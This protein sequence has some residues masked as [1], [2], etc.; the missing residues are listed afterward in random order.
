MLARIATASILLLLL[1]AGSLRAQPGTKPDATP[2]PAVEQAGLETFYVPDK[3]TGKLIP[4]FRALTFDEFEKLYKLQNQLAAPDPGQ[5]YS[6]QSM[7]VRGSVRGDNATLTATLRIKTVKPGWSKVDLR[8][9]SVL[10]TR[11]A[12]YRGPGKAI[13]DYSPEDKHYYCLVDG[14][15]DAVHTIEMQFVVP[16]TELGGERSLQL[17]TPSAVTSTLQLTVPAQGVD[18]SS[19]KGGVFRSAR[20]QGGQ[21]S[22]EFLGL[23]GEFQMRW[24]PGQKKGGGQQRT[25]LE[26]SALLRVSFDGRFHTRSDATLKVNSLSGDFNSFLVRLPAGMRLVPDDETFAQQRYTVVELSEQEKLARKLPPRLR[27]Q[28]L[29][30]VTLVRK[31]SERVEVNLRTVRRRDTEQQPGAAAE[32][33]DAAG[34]EVIGASNQWGYIELAV[35]GDW[36]VQWQA[37]HVTQTGD[38][39]AAMR[40]NN[41]VARFE[42]QQQPCQLMVTVSPRPER[43]R[44]EPAYQLK[45]DAVEAELEARIR[46]QVRGASQLKIN[47]PG[48]TVD[49][50]QPEDLFEQSLTGLESVE[51]LVLTLTPGAA[52]ASTAFD[53][54]IK[55]RHATGIGNEET[56]TRLALP[57]PQT[58]TTAPATLTVLPASEIELE[59]DASNSAGLQIRSIPR[60]AVEGNPGALYYQLRTG[61]A[62]IFSSIAQKR[63]RRV[64][65]GSDTQVK[66]NKDSASVAQTLKFN[67]EFEPVESLLV[68]L[69]EEALGGDIE[70][71]GSA[72]PSPS[73]Q[74]VPD[75][76]EV[77]PPD[78][79]PAGTVLPERPASTDLEANIEPPPSG[80][81]QLFNIL[82]GRS[83]LGEFQ[84]S[85]R[86]DSAL[87]EEGEG[88]AEKNFVLPLAA[89]V[90][91]DIENNTLQLTSAAWEVTPADGVWKSESGKS[92]PARTASL[93]ATGLH[94]QAILKLLRL[95]TVKQTAPRVEKAWLQTTYAAEQRRDRAVFVLDTDD[96]QVEVELPP[97]VEASAAMVT[98]GGARQATAVAG[99]RLQVTLPPVAG[100]HVI[101]IWYMLQEETPSN[102]WRSIMRPQIAGARPPQ[103][104]Y[105]QVV[106]PAQQ[107]VLNTPAGMNAEQVAGWDPFL[108]R[109]EVMTQRELEAWTGSSEQALPPA[110]S[111]TYLYSSFTSPARISLFTVHSLPMMLAASLLVMLCGGL[112]IYWEKARQPVVWMAF[113]SVLLAFAV[114][115]P[116]LAL[117]LAQATA[118]GIVLTGFMALL[119]ML[120][121]RPGVQRAVSPVPLN[122]P[123][124]F[125]PEGSSMPSTMPREASSL[126]ATASIQD[127]VHEDAGESTVYTD[128]PSSAGRE[129]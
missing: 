94:A 21:T 125:V 53:V 108:T 47:M 64:L 118:V 40:Q 14:E 36:N 24:R 1:T 105:Y 45:I 87:P 25:V 48:W 102:G 60:D 85:L 15:V 46:Y 41:V 31:T 96:N 110:T 106:L 81:G 32:G 80:A 78:D 127:R 66:L 119:K 62:P 101:E 115:Y 29:A 59:Y 11:E 34:F 68:W 95:S 112:V 35:Q 30:E 71:N 79:A 100:P 75:A 88:G 61:L 92:T 109:R 44:A 73:I 120:V 42:Y 10:L 63:K 49:S 28:P 54:V 83:M 91:D 114:F 26:A 27:D 103:E 22:L 113:A 77:I 98:V 65:V 17:Q 90:A 74:P 13:V 107:L 126:A 5:R 70:L 16:L 56:R 38:L 93:D 84:L 6:I 12:I 2:A 50:I 122:G 128:R 72:L 99:E 23:R 55:A 8:F 58:T 20:P 37:D 69:P 82:L 104:F 121:S 76:M 51:P 19:V 18:V 97:G 124:V 116:Q 33:V 111:Q 123:S 39:T 117:Q 3:E 129:S 43:V 67:V 86:Y 57:L 7:A 9:D 4:V 52:Q 89:A